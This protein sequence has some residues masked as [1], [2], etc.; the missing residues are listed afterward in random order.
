MRMRRIARTLPAAWLLGA[1]LAG[2]SP[3]GP[4]VADFTETLDLN[5]T[6]SGPR[7]LQDTGALVSSS[8]DLDDSEQIS[9]PSNY[10]DSLVV[11]LSED[12]GLLKLTSTG[13]NCYAT[14]D[15]DISNMDFNPVTLV[16]DATEVTGLRLVRLGAI[17]LTSE[18]DPSFVRSSRFEGNEIGVSLSFLTDANNCPMELA[19]TPSPDIYE[20]NPEPAT[21]ARLTG[22]SFDFRETLDAPQVAALAPQGGVSSARILFDDAV[23]IGAGAELD[24]GDEIQNPSNFVDSM[25]L[26]LDP[27]TGRLSAT[28]TASSCYGTITIELTNFQPGPAGGQILGVALVQRSAFPSDEGQPG[29]HRTVTFQKDSVRIDYA[30]ETVG[31]NLD[32]EG[33]QPDVYQL[34]VP[35]PGATAAATAALLALGARAARSARR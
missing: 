10:H 25:T 12:T 7:V 23:P 32:M 24:E 17:E 28:P 27:A 5:P 3:L 8:P 13:P 21:H 4:V 30:N 34:F 1:P 26:D 14:I 19:N 18:T 35:E 6:Q 29:F 31:C 9:N 16:P 11:D 15:L 33:G 2:A 22:A 20:V